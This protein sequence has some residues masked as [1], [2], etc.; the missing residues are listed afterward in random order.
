MK[1]GST[2]RPVSPRR[3]QIVS[4]TSVIASARA[5]AYMEPRPRIVKVDDRLFE[6]RMRSST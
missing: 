2:C 5:E 6:G 4:K 1:S 3:E